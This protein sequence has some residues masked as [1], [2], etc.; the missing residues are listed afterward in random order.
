VVLF[1]AHAREFVPQCHEPF[2]AITLPHFAALSRAIA[3]KLFSHLSKKHVMTVLSGEISSCGKHIVFPTL[4]IEYVK[5]VES[6]G[7]SA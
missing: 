4:L 5:L 1:G 2:S 3:L 6:P 7:F